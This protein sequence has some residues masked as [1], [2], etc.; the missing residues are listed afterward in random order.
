MSAPKQVGRPKGSPNKV[1]AGM[2]AAVMAAFEDLG[3]IDAFVEWGSAN[4]TEFYKIASRLIPTEVNA[5]VTMV[6]HE[7]ALKA[8]K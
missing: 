5:A 7:E 1:T 6:P 3:G 2:K 4:K 8:L